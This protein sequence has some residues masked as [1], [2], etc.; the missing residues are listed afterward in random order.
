MALF[1]NGADD[2]FDD[3]TFQVL[4]HLSPDEIW[5]SADKAET[6]SVRKCLRFLLIDDKLKG[7]NFCFGAHDVRKIRSDCDCEC[8][9]IR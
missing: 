9:E 2:Y 3:R 5:V 7:Q 6:F 8:D 1:E 4:C